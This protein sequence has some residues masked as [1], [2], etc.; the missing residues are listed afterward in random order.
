[1]DTSFCTT[2]YMLLY[3]GCSCWIQLN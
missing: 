1:M 2:L 3:A